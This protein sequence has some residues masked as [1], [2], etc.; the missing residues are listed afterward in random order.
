MIELE[1]LAHRGFWTEPS[2]KNRRQAIER[3]LRAGFGIETDVRDHNDTIVIS[4]DPPGFGRGPDMTFEQLLSL[5]RD[6]DASETLALNIKSDGL[7][8]ELNRLLKAY[9]TP[10]YFV[11]DMSVPDMLTYTKLG[12]CCFARQSELETPI[13][14][15]INSSFGRT[16]GIWLDSLSSVWYSPELFREHLK[17]GLDVCLVSPELHGRNPNPWWGELKRFLKTTRLDDES[18]T[19]R[20]MLCTDS[21]DKFDHQSGDGNRCDQSH[22]L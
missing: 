20:L 11:F 15:G 17:S 5:Y 12:M 18:N 9:G 10:E 6:L 13:L 4:H 1:C 2:E 22:H 19:G 3:A 16:Q 7:A 8:T 21:P 14:C